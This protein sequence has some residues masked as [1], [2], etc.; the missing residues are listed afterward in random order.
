MKRILSI[1]GGGIRGVIPLVML[2]ELERRTGR[3]CVDLFDFFVG[4]STGAIITLGLNVPAAGHPGK[5]RYSAQELL[6][7]YIAKGPTIFKAEHWHRLKLLSYFTDE[8]YNSN[9]LESSLKEFYGETLLNQ[10]LRDVM[11]TAY[12]IERRQPF[13]FKFLHQ[14]D[15][16][17]MLNCPMWEVARSATAAPTYFEP[18]LLKVPGTNHS[19][20]LIDGGVFANNPSMCAYGEASRQYHGHELMLVSLGSGHYAKPLKY[21]VMK[22]LRVFLWARPIVDIMMYGGL[23]VVDY[24]LSQIMECGQNYWRFQCQLD[25]AFPDYVDDASALHLRR[26]TQLAQATLEQ[27]SEKIDQLCEALTHRPRRWWQIFD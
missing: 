21:E 3:C 1:D 4:T 9:G 22:D 26:L 2:A 11:I 12:D 7:R 20:A 27:Q 14:K 16:R 24:Q 25:T 18:Y 6:D 17:G 13:F 23:E 5:P 8:K 15:Q 10:S 19:K